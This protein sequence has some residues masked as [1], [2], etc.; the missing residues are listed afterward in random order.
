MQ[1]Q[2]T[3]RRQVLQ[4]PYHQMRDQVESPRMRGERDFKL[5]DHAVSYFKEKR[6]TGY[7]L[8]K[9]LYFRML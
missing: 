7:F 5:A 8:A 9:I 2:D 6:D 4:V 1:V 3:G